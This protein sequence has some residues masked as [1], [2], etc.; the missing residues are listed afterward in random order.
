MSSIA[1]AAGAASH[2][3][4]STIASRL[5]RAGGFVLRYSLVLFL[6]LFGAL[7]WTP[8]EAQGIEPMVRHSPFFFWLYPI[9][10]IQRG[11]EVI[12]LIELVIG[13]LIASRRWSS[14]ASATGSIA[15]CGV[16]VV[17]LSFL[18]TTPNVGQSAPFLLKDV[19]LLGAALWSAGEALAAS[20]I[21]GIRVPGTV[22]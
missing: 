12:G 10:G 15:A 2:A 7:K 21:R 11:S 14:V 1:Y 5:S 18:F 17:T 4:G 6:L 13:L 16:F 19:A 22:A 3:R 9:F 20:Q 8:A